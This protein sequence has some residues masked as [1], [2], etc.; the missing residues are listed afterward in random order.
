MGQI[1]NAEET[2]VL[3]EMPPNYPLDE[4][5]GKKIPMRT[6]GYEKQHV[7]VML[8]ITATGNKLSPFLIFKQ[9]TSP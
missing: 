8:V 3:L 1:G 9:K 4:K 5:R 7:T 6:S 2:P